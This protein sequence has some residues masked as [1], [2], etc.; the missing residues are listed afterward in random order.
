MKTCLGLVPHAG[1]AGRKASINAESLPD[2]TKGQAWYP[3]LVDTIA[4]GAIA[5]GDHSFGTRLAVSVCILR[6]R[7]LSIAAQLKDGAW[8]QASRTRATMTIPLTSEACGLP[9]R[10]H[11]LATV[12]VRFGG[13]GRRAAE[14][15]CGSVKSTAICCRCAE[16]PQ[17]NEAK[18]ATPEKPGFRHFR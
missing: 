1:L 13:P 18:V 11:R 8:A 16:Q 9:Y 2:L 14:S 15:A 3:A 4:S 7:G 17:R 6:S 10:S 5:T 12:P